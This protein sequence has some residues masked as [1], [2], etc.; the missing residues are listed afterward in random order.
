M[1]DIYYGGYSEPTPE[2]AVVQ[3][4]EKTMSGTFYE[5]LLGAYTQGWHSAHDGASCD[6]EREIV[7]GSIIKDHPC[8][9]AA[10]KLL[11]ACMLLVY[12][13]ECGDPIDSRDLAEANQAINE[14]DPKPIQPDEAMCA[15][16]EI[17]TLGTNPVS[18]QGCT[19]DVDFLCL[20]NKMKQ[21]AKK[22][23]EKSEE[24]S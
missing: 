20:I 18:E 3:P 21:V 2:P 4:T 1:S 22:V 10:Q 6:G 14:A 23:I 16:M 8:E 5:A 13:H 9:A 24:V 12:R 15:L 17:Y 11:R 19:Y 7:T